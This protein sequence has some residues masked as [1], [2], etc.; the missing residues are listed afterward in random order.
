MNWTQIE[1]KWDQ[2]KGDLKSRWGKLTDDDLKVASGNLDALV[3][4]IVE[5]YGVKK[6]QAHRDVSEWAER[7]RTKIGAATGDR[8]AEARSREEPPQHRA[9]EGRT[10]SPARDPRSEPSSTENHRS[11]N[12]GMHRG[13]S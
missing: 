12:D 6:E 11:D 2:L 10:G 3:G 13:R 9:T 7:I 8:N 5:R 1:G 4:K